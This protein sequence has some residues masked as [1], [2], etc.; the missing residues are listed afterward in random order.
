MQNL[1][2]P[3]I[4]GCSYLNNFNRLKFHISGSIDKSVSS[5][6]I[7]LSH[8]F[9]KQM[10]IELLKRN[11]HLVITFGDEPKVDDLSLIFDYTIIEGI[12][13]FNLNNLNNEKPIVTAF[14]YHSFRSKV[15]LERKLLI[16][17]LMDYDLVRIKELPQLS[18]Y[19]GKLRSEL[20]KIT[21]VLIILGGS[22]GVNDL[23]EKFHQGNKIIIPIN[24][25]LGKPNAL[26]CIDMLNKG[27]L[28][29]YPLNIKEDVISEITKFCLEKELDIEKSI[30]NVL[31]LILNLIE[32]KGEEIVKLIITDLKSLQEKNRAIKPDENKLSIILVEFL[33]RSM[34]SLGYF[35]HTQEPS[36]KTEM[37]YNDQVTHGGMGEL[38]IRIVDKNNE[39]K[40]ICENFILT[41]L[42][43][44]VISEH[45][46]KIFDYDCNGL[47]VN[48][49]IIY[50]KADDFYPLW[51]KYLDFLKKFNWKYPLVDTYIEDISEKR[52][53]PAEIKLSLTRHHREGIICKIYHIFVNLK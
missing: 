16:S 40:H 39:L 45:V 37:G 28:N 8:K 19:G 15:P 53:C 29:L 35:P 51:M 36:G 26:N 18:S 6:I 13:E 47:P 52:D 4:N 42:N 11:G 33:R 49:I 23:I 22:R 17:E 3:L 50:S 31:K 2:L 30:K 12:K 27:M 41:Y 20:T 48:F 25:N 5:E 44:S 14:L 34:K 10:T 24:I 46:N 7:K 38:D 9:I 43:S 21:D 1:N 32:E